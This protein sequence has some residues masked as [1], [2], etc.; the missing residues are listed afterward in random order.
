MSINPGIWR[1]AS[2]LSNLRV[3]GEVVFLGFVGRP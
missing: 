1:K 2:R 3:R